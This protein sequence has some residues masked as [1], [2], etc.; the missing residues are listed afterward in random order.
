MG[1][2]PPGKLLLGHEHVVCGRGTKDIG[3][4]GHCVGEFLMGDTARR[5]RPRRTT[6]QV[7]TRT[8][9]HPRSGLHAITITSARK[10]L[11]PSRTT[12]VST[13]FATSNR[14]DDFFGSKRNHHAYP[15]FDYGTILSSKTKSQ[16]EQN[17]VFYRPLNSRGVWQPRFSGHKKAA[18]VGAFAALNFG[19][20]RPA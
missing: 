14:S 17:P 5:L 6:N 3:V 20:L 19:F 13:R 9:G 12:K 10:T 1:F 15:L 4:T 11:A 2:I 16:T 18:N 8:C 7:P